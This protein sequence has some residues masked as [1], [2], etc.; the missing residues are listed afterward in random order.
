MACRLDFSEVAESVVRWGPCLFELSE[1]KR[2]A[3]SVELSENV[4]SAEKDAKMVAALVE[5]LVDRWGM[6][7]E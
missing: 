1:E 2:V 7:V 4:E 6:T 5:K 3:K